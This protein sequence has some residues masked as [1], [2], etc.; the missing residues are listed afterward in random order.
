MVSCATYDDYFVLAFYSQKLSDVSKYLTHSRIS[1]ALY[2]L[3]TDRQEQGNKLLSDKALFNEC[4]SKYTL[5]DYI[6]LH[7]GISDTDVLIFL[8]KHPIFIA[9][10]LDG[11]S[12]KSIELIDSAAFENT[13]KLIRYLFSNNLLLLEEKLVNHKGDSRKQH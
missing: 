9:K 5:R 13:K 1:K 12:G 2:V 10:A 4:F 8:E 7:P 3:N 11:S 6:Y